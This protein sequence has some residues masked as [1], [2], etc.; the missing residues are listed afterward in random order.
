MFTVTDPARVHA[1]LTD[2]RHTVPAVA[3]AAGPGVAWL[4]A[5]VARFAPPRRHR[6]LRALAEAELATVAPGALRSAARAWRGGRTGPS[7]PLLAEALGLPVAADDVA[8]VSRHYQPHTGVVPGEADE[9]VR[10]LASAC[11]GGYGAGDERTA[12]RIGLLVQACRPTD[13]L[14]ERATRRG[15]PAAV[16][17]VLAA[18]APVRE[19]RRCTPTGELVA[20]DLAAARLPF[21][22]GA[23]TCPGMA[24][25]I[26]I[27]EGTAQG[28]AEGTARQGEDR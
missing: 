27:A 18:E 7:V 26:A 16:A 20:L 12:A 3:D 23:H 2:P 9:A 1:I 10:R 22:A 15:G 21:G 25:A 19:T 28:S 6:R 14:A 4:R 17:E 13:L 24:H 5:N 11:R 8:L